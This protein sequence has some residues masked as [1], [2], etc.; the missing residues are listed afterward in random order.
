M[1][2]F[3]TVA[4]RQP[5]KHRAEIDLM[6]PVLDAPANLPWVDLDTTRVQMLHTV[7]LSTAFAAELKELSGTDLSVGEIGERV[8][9]ER[10]H[11]GPV[12][13]LSF[14]DTDEENTKIV[15]P[16]LLGALEALIEKGRDFSS[17]QLADELRPVQPG[18]AR[19]YQG[20]MFLTISETPGYSVALPPVLWVSLIGA[21]T[22]VVAAAG[23]VML[24][25]RRPRV[26]SGDDFPTDVGMPLITHVGRV[27]R[28]YAATK[29][30]Y[31]HVA[32]GA[33]EA[34]D[35][36]A[37]P[38]R[39]VI[40]CPESDSASRGLAMGVAAGLAASGERVVLVDGQTG[41]PAMTMRLGGWARAGMADI[42]RGDT[43]LSSSIR[44]VRR[45]RLPVSVRRTLGRSAG[46]LRFIPAGRRRRG[47]DPRVA[48]P[49]LDRRAPRV[50]TVL[51][52]PPLLGTVPVAPSLK[53]ADVV[54]Y[55]LVEGRTVT[56]DAEDGAIRVRTFCNAPAGV[57]LSD[58]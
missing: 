58:V 5:P 14:V 35:G 57:V 43:D 8:A 36:E 38:R 31:M 6:V 54:L 39:I 13:K 21:M 27:G 47:V 46:N 11:F 26:N 7:A 25:Q 52:A 33:L 12:I 4:G 34:A 30:Q 28:R 23:L 53:W 49:V 44:W 41:R 37:M 10:P 20:D 16:H 2:L 17:E 40:A 48:P 1:V 15:G 51:L 56:F 45:W 42:T 3:G 18:E 50:I 32:L 22:G 9:V 55:C 19:Y 24:Q 29:E